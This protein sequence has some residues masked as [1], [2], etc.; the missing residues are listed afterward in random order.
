M[1]VTIEGP[2][3]S[4]KSSVTKE[5]VKRL[6]NEGIEVILTREPGGTPI[7]EEIRN[8][9]LDKKNTNTPQTKISDAAMARLAQLMND[10]PS[11]IKLHGTEWAITSLKAGTQWLIAE[12]ACKVVQNENATMGDV[13]KQFAVNMP[14]ICR[15]LTLALLNDKQK[16]YGDEYKQVYDLLMW[17][18]YS[19]KDW[20]VFFAEII[21]LMDVDFFFASTNAVKTLRQRT[22]DRKITMEEQK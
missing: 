15:V 10:S 9:I 6:N 11:I 7:A 18:D 5:V 13:V 1:F 19:Q 14:A 21:Q 16:I 17:G 2:E 3:G 22:L 20:A 4:G 12:E 8:V